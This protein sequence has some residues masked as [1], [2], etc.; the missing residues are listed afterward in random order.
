MKSEENATS[1]AA[2]ARDGV[3]NARVRVHGG[4]DAVTAGLHGRCR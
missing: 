4:E 2:H 3:E 1:A